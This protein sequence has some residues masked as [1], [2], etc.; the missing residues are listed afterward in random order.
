[1][2]FC[3]KCGKEVVSG[4]SFCQTCGA[5]LSSPQSVAQ[6]LSTATPSDEDYAAFIG[7]NTYTYVNKFKKFNIGGI[8]NFAA[9]WHW[10][11][12]LVGFWWMLYRK[13]YLW[14]LLDFVLSL[15]PYVNIVAWIAF[16]IT[17]NYIYYKH[18]KK[19]L[20]EI[21]M[22]QQSPEMQRN[23]AIITGGTNNVPVIIGIIIAII[24]VIG[25]LAAIAI[26]GYIGM[27]A[28]KGNTQAQAEGQKACEE[29][30]N[31]LLT[32]SQDKVDMFDLVSKGLSGSPD[33]ELIIQSGTRDNLL[34]TAKHK[35]GSKIYMTDNY[36]N[37]TEKSSY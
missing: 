3:N 4:S 1:M 2:V 34:I 12:F 10:P 31:I 21:K 9:T 6:P 23:M 27:Q 14:A 35:K 20:L 13:L 25:I 5:Q 11:A 8:D 36:C 19:K 33:V 37:V 17:A 22:I 18:S 16:G 24:A 26:P 32:T 30:R 29:A 7:K 15:I 28:R